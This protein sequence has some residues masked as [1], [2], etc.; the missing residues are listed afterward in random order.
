MECTD[1]LEK[2]FLYVCFLFLYMPDLM[3]VW[4]VNSVLVCTYISF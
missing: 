3:I 4:G 1:L 2:L